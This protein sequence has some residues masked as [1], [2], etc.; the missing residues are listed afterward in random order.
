[1][2]R[3]GGEKGKGRGQAG[4]EVTQGGEG[5]RGEGEGASVVHAAGFDCS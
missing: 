2:M 3:D 1:M 4:A 5:G